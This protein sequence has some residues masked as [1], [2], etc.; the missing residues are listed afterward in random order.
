MFHS[1]SGSAYKDWYA[2]MYECQ[3]VAFIDRKCQ[4]TSFSTF[5]HRGIFLKLVDTPN[6]FPGAHRCK[7]AKRYKLTAIYFFP[8]SSA[9]RVQVCALNCTNLLCVGSDGGDKLSETKQEEWV[10]RMGSRF[11]KM[12][13]TDSHISAPCFLFVFWLTKVLFASLQRVRTNCSRSTINLF[14]RQETVVETF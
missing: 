5:R 9:V 13:A 8:H 11:L 14:N 2:L 10:I 12:A 3:C 6:F 7:N 1:W 4:R